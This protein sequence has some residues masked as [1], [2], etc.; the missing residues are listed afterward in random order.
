MILDDNGFSDLLTKLKP[1]IK[2]EEGEKA[3]K[4]IKESKEKLNNIIRDSMKEGKCN[5]ENIVK[6]IEKI[7][8]QD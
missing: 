8:L 2:G 3:Y 7:C 6:E 5:F 1:L 4:N